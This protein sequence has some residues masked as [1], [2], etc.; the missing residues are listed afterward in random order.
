MDK[1]TQD[2]AW[3]CLPREF[4]E[5]VQK[6]WELTYNEEN[7]L[8][9][10]FLRGKCLI[11]RK[12]F[13]LD[14]LTSDA[15]GEE[16]LTVPRKWV[17]DMYAANERIMDDHIGELSAVVSEEI[18]RVL[19]FLFGSEC[20]PDKVDSLAGNVASK[21]A[22]PTF[23]DDCK[24]QCKSCNLSQNIA[25]C[26]K[27]PDNDLCDKLIQRGF[28]NHNRLH[29]AAMVMQGIMANPSKESVNM[30]VAGIVHLS[31]LMADALLSECEKGGRYDTTG[32]D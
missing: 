21:P 31:L 29:I 30:D 24:S 18:N 9:D 12:Y 7:I 11:M 20:M 1:T 27:D 16:M 5:A 22:E 8:H 6:E 13:G 3:A 25:N 28:K 10:A 2:L 19:H 17:H 32:T 23:T 4:R 26:D 15:E 14:N